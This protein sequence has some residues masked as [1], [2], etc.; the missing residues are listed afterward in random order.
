M[1]PYS[2]VDIG[3]HV[4]SLSIRKF[5]DLGAVIKAVRESRGIKQESLATDL[6]FDRNY[7]QQLENGRPNLYI[8]R[9]FR[10]LNALNITVTVTYRLGEKDE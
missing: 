3:V 7:L 10:T 1:H 5:R 2:C 4:P 9:L 8:T 6:A